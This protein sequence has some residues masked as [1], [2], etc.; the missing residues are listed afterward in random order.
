MYL[1]SASAFPAGLI[2]AILQSKQDTDVMRQAFSLA[3]LLTLV[4]LP[5][6]SMG[7]DDPDVLGRAKTPLGARDY[8]QAATILEDALAGASA[9]E[10]PAMIALLR[11]SYRG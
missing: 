10:R 7:A 9:A 4:C 5:A 11:Q 1:R 3:L 8:Q 2:P 6:G